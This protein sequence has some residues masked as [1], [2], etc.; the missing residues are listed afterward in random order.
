MMLDVSSTSPGVGLA[1]QAWWRP[2][3]INLRDVS[4]HQNAICARSGRP[5]RAGSARCPSATGPSTG[6]SEHRQPTGPANR[7]TRL[8]AVCA[9]CPASEATRG[10]A[11]PSHGARV[12]SVEQLG[13]D[14]VTASIPGVAPGVRSGGRRTRQHPRAREPERWAHRGA[15]TRRTLCVPEC[16]R[17]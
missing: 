10:S 14:S 1:T 16:A 3:C 15:R 5:M 2:P 9:I 11:R 12:C 4:H 6:S 7:T 17:Q 8:R 13:A